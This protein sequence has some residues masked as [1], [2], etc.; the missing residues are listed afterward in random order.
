MSANRRIGIFSG[1]FDPFHN[2]HLLL[3]L[4]AMQECNL[5]EVVIFAEKLPLRK[6]TVASFQD[7]LMMIKIATTKYKNIKV[8]DIEQSN[9]TIDNTLPILQKIYP[10]GE[11]WYIAGSDI[12]QYLTQ[13]Q[14]I[15]RLLNNMGLCIALRS[16]AERASTKERLAHLANRHDNLSLHIIL[17]TIS[18]ASSSL[19]RKQISSSTE[20]QFID[21]EV[22]QYIQQHKLYGA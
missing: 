1:T 14:N 7:R 15:D 8:I 20:P 22:L 5:D 16:D 21:T 9:I 4:K 13:W 18:E 19:V 3:C 2:G 12:L 10:D 6:I 17:Q 11:Y